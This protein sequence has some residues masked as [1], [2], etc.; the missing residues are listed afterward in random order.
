MNFLKKIKKINIDYVMYGILILFFLFMLFFSS[1]RDMIKDET[2]Y[3]HETWLMS[4]V[5]K[6]GEWI[7]NYAVGLHGLLFKLPMAILFLLTGPSVELVTIFNIL[8]ATYVG[9]LFY[10]LSK[11]ILKKD[12]YAL[13]STILLLT[14]F[15]FFSSTPTYL[16]EIP[17]LLAVV[18]FMYALVR[19][20]EK[21]Y[22][23]LIFL[24]LLDS[25]EYVFFVF[26]LFYLIWLFIDSKE[27]GFK[28]VFPVIK[29]YILVF[30]PSIAWILLMFCTGVIPLNMYLASTLGLIDTNFKYFFSHFSVDL[31]TLNLIEGGRDM[32]LITIRESWSFGVKGVVNIFNVFLL[33]LGKILYPR[34]FSF[35]SV[36]KVVM[37]PVIATSFLYIKEYFVSKKKDLRIYASLGILLI[38]WLL[39]YFLRASHGRYLLPVV[40]AISIIF[41]YLLFEY[42]YTQKQKRSL[43]IGTIIFVILGFLFETSYVL[44]KIFIE[45]FI[46]LIFLS[47]ILKPKKKYLKYL[48]IS[49]ISTVCIGVSILFAYTQ[50][51]VYGFLNWGRNRQ[52]E[53]ISEFI[54]KK[55][56]YWSNNEENQMLTSVYI[57]E[58]Y[59]PAEWKWKLNEIV[60]RTENL[61]FLG[62]KTSYVFPVVDID[63]FQSKLR[64]ENI[65]KLVLYVSR[66]KTKF[67][68][69]NYLDVFL[70]Q[71]WLEL[72]DMK[73]F[74][75]L[76]IYIF[77]IK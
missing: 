2:L 38:V 4:E 37:F 16:R 73:E 55:Q 45:L 66:V 9:F 48:L 59:A 5:I 46:Y 58:T 44:P 53:D 68:D 15:H 47:T 19:N 11:S 75:G 33:Y 27:K 23:G 54:P 35:V 10:K 32:P 18:L 51:Q 76:N 50:G 67:A 36:P 57:G 7:G 52:V 40:P 65:T 1:F 64:D 26:A 69:Q 74:K 21:G 71:D 25:K 62:Q 41:I 24:L 8:L 6:S 30:L 31:A 77:D 12:T 14:T 63:E 42:T 39:I 28:K 72:R 60:P 3:F 43:L 17:S 22:M 34:T 70:K 49:L 20:W 61:K 56:K 13:L 29:K